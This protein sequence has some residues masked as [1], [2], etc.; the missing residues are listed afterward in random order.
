MIWASFYRKD[1]FFMLKIRIISLSA[2]L[3]LSGA[4]LTALALSAPDAPVY[5]TPPVLEPP[6]ALPPEPTSTPA[7]TANGFWV[8]DFDGYAAVF[9]NTDRV[10]P[11]ET[12]GIP[13][14]S[15]RMA[16]QEMLREGVFFEDY[17]DVIM[18][19]EDF[20]P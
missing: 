18:F 10:V 13:V 20:G 7:A 3:A 9:H 1:V 12:T 6:P 2:A 11:I 5:S 16:D 4:F 8:C 14:R 15:L 17:M 19:L